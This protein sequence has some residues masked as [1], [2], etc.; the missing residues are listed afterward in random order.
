MSSIAVWLAALSHPVQAQPVET[1]ASLAVV[2]PVQSCAG[3]AQLDLSQIGGAGSKV[4]S[5]EE[6]RSGGIPVCSV[7]LTLAPAIH[8]QVLL[9]TEGWTQRYLQVGCGGLCGNITLRSGAS[10]GCQVLTDGGFV[11][12]A[13]D[14]GHSAREMEWGLDEQRR[15]DFAYRAQHLTALAAKALIASFYGQAEK[16][17]YFNGCSDGGREALVEAQRYPEDFDGIVAGAP[18]TLFQV[19]NTL[20]HGWL[21]V[22][23][24]AKDGST[25]LTSDRL[26]LV[27]KAVV[28]ACDALDGVKD[29]LISE[30]AKCNFD[31]ATITCKEGQKDTS[32]CL[33]TAESAVVRKIYEGPKD[34]KTGLPLTAGQPQPGSELN[35]Q[36][37]FVA[38][39]RR[40]HFMSQM[41]ATPV[42]QT[43]AFS[44]AD[45]RFELNDLQ[46][47][48]ETLD[49]LRARHPLFDATSTDL[50]AFEKAGGKLIL[51][52]GLADQHISP[53]NTLSYHKALIDFMGDQSVHGFERLYLLPGTAHCGGGEGPSNLDLLTPMMAWVEN[54][55][56]PDGIMTTSTGARSDFGQPELP[57]KGKGD[58]GPPPQKKLDYPPLPAMTRPVYPYP[59]V[60]AYSGK[61][62]VND[63]AN[64]Q[65][66][67][68][69]EIVKLRD[70]PGAD[71]FSP[72]KPAE[73]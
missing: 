40:G 35:W 70:W 27:H 69:G 63:G 5:A 12:A 15:V 20:Y 11:M 37:V 8:T 4:T 73:R 50:K 53:A 30:P 29:G 46:F 39:E 18:A 42:L 43:I 54:G 7:N 41:I 56:A 32:T 45:P 67:N 34:E 17:S 44:K 62:D 36:G 65:K 13:T 26:P 25:I 23:N 68:A 48:R 10:N 59:Y 52:H 57:A 64:W 49:A 22:S 3:L 19:Q 72:F 16:F 55:H 58:A 47:T 14:M 66:G 60:A 61:G 31:I 38:D 51:W 6:T 2:K 71:L 21:A 33:T 1:I 24:T 28:E 9:P